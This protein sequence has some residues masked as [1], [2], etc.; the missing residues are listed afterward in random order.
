M[1]SL[2]IKCQLFMEYAQGAS[3]GIQPEHSIV[4][5]LLNEST[6]SLFF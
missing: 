2:K 3:G 5:V 6:A 1:M 4:T